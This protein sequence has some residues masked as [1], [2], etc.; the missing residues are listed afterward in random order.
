MA[1]GGRQQGGGVVRFHPAAGQNLDA[2]GG[3]LL[4][5]PD[6]IRPRRGGTGLTA[7][8]HPSHPQLYQHVQSLPPVGHHVDGPAEHALLLSDDLQHGGAAGLVHPAVGVEAAEH[9][10]VRPRRQQ[11][12][13]VGQ[14]GGEL[15]LTVAEPPLPGPHHGHNGDGHLP[16]HLHG[17]Y[18]GSQSPK[19][20]G[21]IQLHPVGPGLCG[22]QHILCRAAAYFQN[23]GNTFFSHLGL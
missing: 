23:H 7:G 8:E 3:I 10:A 15:R 11:G 19:K 2:S 5:G 20:E 17:P 9:D 13:G 4:H 16:G 21:R 12:A 6:G 18:G 1:A 22:N 14:H